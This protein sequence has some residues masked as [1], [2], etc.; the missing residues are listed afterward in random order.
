MNFATNLKRIC[1]LRGTTPTGLLKS[2]GVPTNKVSAW[3][4]GALPKQEMLIRLANELGCSVMEFFADESYLETMKLQSDIE[5][6]EDE[7]D[8]VRVYR[9]LSRRDK[10]EFM[11]KVYEFEK[12][13]KL[14]VDKPNH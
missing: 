14:E 13:A 9:L 5:Q 7:I 12:N 2:M 1:K 10:H 6:D 4:K 11:A 8:I 3:N